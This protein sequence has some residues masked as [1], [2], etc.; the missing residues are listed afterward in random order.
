M[1][2]QNEIDRL[3]IEPDT[4]V[5]IEREE[6]AE[7]VDLDS[8]AN[9]AKLTREDKIRLG[10]L[11]TKNHAGRHFTDTHDAEWLDRMEAWGW[12]FVTRPIHKETGIPYSRE[13]WTVDVAPGI[14]DWF[15][16][17]GNLIED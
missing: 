15:D 11:A 16:N 8:I 7:E 17:C 1:L 12:I 14:A 5:W 6:I 2:D 9:E 10:M 13:Y 4:T 3:G